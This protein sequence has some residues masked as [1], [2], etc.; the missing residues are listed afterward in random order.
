MAGRAAA[1]D[2]SAGVDGDTSSPQAFAGQTGAGGQ[3]SELGVSDIRVHGAEA[4]EGTEA[5]IGAGQHAFAA[6]DGGEALD[7]LRDQFRM[8]DEIR[9]RI[10]RAGDED[11]I[12]GDIGFR[13]GAPFVGVARVG[14]FE[15]DGLWFGREDDVDDFGQVDVVRVWPFVVA[16]AEVHADALGG[17]IFQGGVERFD[18]ARCGDAKMGRILITEADVTPHSQIRTVDLQQQAGFGDALVFHFHDIDQGGEVVF[19]AG[20]ILVGLEDGDDAGRSGV[21]ESF[22]GAGGFSGRAQVG[23]VLF[24]RRQVFDADGAADDRPMVLR[25]AALLRQALFE[26]GEFVQ[27]FGGGARH[28]GN[29][30]AGE[31]VAHVGGVADFAHLAITDDIDAGVHLTQGHFTDG[32]R[33]HDVKFAFVVGFPAVLG[34]ELVDDVLGAWQAADVGGEDAFVALVHGQGQLLQINP[35][36]LAGGLGAVIGEG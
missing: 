22:A 33:H 15:L 4:G 34:E 29:F 31:A 14:G 13:P 12:F 24:Q 17:Y 9:G 23:D 32:A 21:H 1:V 36:Q 5:A 25:G 11:F 16:P 10:Q 26:S 19:F 7:A 35:A 30:E 2:R 8:L 28:F 3:G 18:L 20:V 27:V 6:D